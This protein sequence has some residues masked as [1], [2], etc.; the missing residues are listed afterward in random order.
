MP[1]LFWTGP[2]KIQTLLNRCL[3]DDQP[4]PPSDHGVYAVTLKTWRNKPGDHCDPLYVGSTTGKEGR[5]CTR[6]GD[7][8]ADMFGFFGEMAGHS[9]G[10]KSLHR[11]CLDHNINPGQLYIG[12]AGR[13]PW[14][15]RCAEIDAVKA[16]IGSW[17]RRKE[18]GL[19]NKNRPPRCLDHNMEL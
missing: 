3:D 6:I 13:D 18:I 4:W 5:F 12:W 16:I 8:I 11:W 2:F 14:C 9:S 15:S 7:L 19:L 17:E 1:E 10:G